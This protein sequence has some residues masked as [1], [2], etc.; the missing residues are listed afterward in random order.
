MGVSPDGTVPVS[1]HIDR[2]SEPRAVRAP[3][4]R[5]TSN[6]DHYE[7]STRFVIRNTL[8]HSCDFRLG[9]TGR[10]GIIEESM[11]M[12]SERGQFTHFPSDRSLQQD[13][14]DTCAVPSKML[15][16]GLGPTP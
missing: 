14:S 6:T 8:A 15:I 16:P 5:D 4:L 1:G 9:R 11:D 7:V 2:Q 10:T 3:P 13:R 12:F